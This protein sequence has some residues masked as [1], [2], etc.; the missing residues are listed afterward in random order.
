LPCKYAVVLFLIVAYPNSYKPDPSIVELV[1]ILEVCSIPFKY[2]MLVD[3]FLVKVILL[4]DAGILVVDD[5]TYDV[6]LPLT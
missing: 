3:P 4:I 2:G 1:N 6:T 5:I